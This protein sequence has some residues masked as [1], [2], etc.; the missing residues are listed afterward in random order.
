MSI[1][2]EIRE[3]DTRPYELW[4]IVPTNF[5]GDAENFVCEGEKDHC[6]SVKEQLES[7]A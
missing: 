5:G 6:L 2:Y 3:G 4:S 1:R 7:A